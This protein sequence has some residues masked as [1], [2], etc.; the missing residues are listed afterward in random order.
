MLMCVFSY[1]CVHAI[2]L[3]KS[4]STHDSPDGPCC[5]SWMLLNLSSSV[6][7]L[8][9]ASLLLWQIS[10]ITQTCNCVILTHTESPGPPC[11]HGNNQNVLSTPHCAEI[12]KSFMRSQESCC[13]SQPCHSYYKAYESSSP[14]TCRITLWG[15]APWH[16]RTP[17]PPN[18]LDIL[19]NG[20]PVLCFRW[21]MDGFGRPSDQRCICLHQR[22]VSSALFFS[23]AAAEPAPSVWWKRRLV[24]A[25]RGRC[26]W[27]DRDTQSVLQ[28]SDKSRKTNDYL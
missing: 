11:C 15:A 26:G 28:G 12:K 4:S 1:R 7:V 17:R 8:H 23:C 16:L 6:S 18:T 25:G 21:K 3:S 13:E 2:C 14:I 19:P 20:R 10:R 24:A 22:L 5:A 27:S 9:L